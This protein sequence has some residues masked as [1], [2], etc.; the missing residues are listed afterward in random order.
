M[1]RPSKSRLTVE[2]IQA[3]LNEIK[4]IELSNQLSNSEQIS[5]FSGLLTDDAYVYQKQITGQNVFG[6]AVSTWLKKATGTRSIVENHNP[7]RDIQ[8]ALYNVRIS[9]VGK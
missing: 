6:D 8:L 7:V 3:S 5:Y 4:N 1:P 9:R 2:N